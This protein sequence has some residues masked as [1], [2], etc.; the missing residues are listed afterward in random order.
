MWQMPVIILV[1]HISQMASGHPKAPSEQTLEPPLIRSSQQS[2][3]TRDVTRRSLTDRA[4]TSGITNRW[5]HR[6]VGVSL[7]APT[8]YLFGANIAIT[9]S[10]GMY[11]CVCMVWVGVR[12]HD[13]TKTPGRNDLKLATV[14]GLDLDT[15]SKPINFGLK[16]VKDQRLRVIISNFWHQLPPGE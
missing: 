4:Q 15:I 14:V 12:Q 8:Y 10:R 13:E 5:E 1:P 3:T 9:L 11:V 16:K 6:P 7:S 2:H